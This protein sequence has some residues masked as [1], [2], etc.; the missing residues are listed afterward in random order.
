MTQPPLSPGESRSASPPRVTVS[1]EGTPRRR[2]RWSFAFALPLALVGAACHRTQSPTAPTSTATTTTVAEPSIV[3]V[4]NGRIAV[5]G[6]A[7][8][9][10]TVNANGTVNVTLAALSGVNVPSTVWLGLGL[11][12]PSAE[13]CST[14]T[15]VN[16]QTGS[17]AQLTGTYAPGT[18]CVRVFY[19]GNLAAPV[20][21]SVAIA[22]P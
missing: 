20:A 1:G 6:A 19:I 13:D 16:T 21:F 2:R 8:Y 5:G 18:Y 10:F 7:F 22:H 17:A 4:F 3:E 11:G 12:T 14:S 15:T 9:A